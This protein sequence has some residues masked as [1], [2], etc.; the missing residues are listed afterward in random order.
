M[1][2]IPPH[3]GPRDDW[4]QVLK[5]GG[6]GG[7]NVNSWLVDMVN[8]WQF[9][10]DDGLSPDDAWRKLKMSYDH[11]S[12]AF[13]NQPPTPL[14]SS[15]LIPPAIARLVFGRSL[16]RDADLTQPPTVYLDHS[17]HVGWD[18]TERSFK[19]P[20]YRPRSDW[21]QTLETMQPEQGS[22]QADLVNY[23]KLRKAGE[24]EKDAWEAVKMTPEN[25]RLALIEDE[26]SDDAGLIPC[27]PGGTETVAKRVLARS[28]ATNADHDDIYAGLI[29]EP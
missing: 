13:S 24:Q 8:Y 15:G 5:N 18:G 23:W 9:T 29:L 22:W 20:R 3:Y 27:L 7:N 17:I 26:T 11:A 2:Y 4:R 12:K 10:E 25:A 21:Q 16:A 6:P 14:N 19:A 28:C 1:A